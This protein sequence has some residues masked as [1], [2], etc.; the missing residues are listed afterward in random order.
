M[1]DNHTD[2]LSEVG[3][4]W[5]GATDPAMVKKHPVTLM[6]FAVVLKRHEGVLKKLEL[7]FSLG[8]G[9]RLGDGNQAFTWIHIEDLVQAILFLVKHPEIVGPINL[10]APECVSQ[11]TFA[12]SLAKTMHRPLLF[13]MPA[14]LINLLFGQMGKELLLGGQN[15]Y[16]ERLQ[17]IKHWLL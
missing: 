8:L 11:K 1:L 2:F 3:Q 15:I 14:S 9:S 7:P 17:K 6:R 13:S 4:A 16:P 12:A 5:E 10:C